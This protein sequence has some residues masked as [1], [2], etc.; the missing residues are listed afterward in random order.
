MARRH[1][2]LFA[3]EQMVSHWPDTWDSE[4]LHYFKGQSGAEYRSVRDR[5]TR[6]VKMLPDGAGETICWR[7]AACTRRTPPEPALKDGSDTTAARSS[8]SIRTCRCT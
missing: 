5:G 7:C 2:Q 4:V 1:G 3:H 6:F 8:A